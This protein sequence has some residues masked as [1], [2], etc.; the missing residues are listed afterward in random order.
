MRDDWINNLF[1][2]C[3][4]FII[5]NF[6]YLIIFICLFNNQKVNELLKIYKKKKL[7]GFDS[8]F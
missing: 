5:I 3:L 7:I 2:N 4:F 6:D 8:H 1:S